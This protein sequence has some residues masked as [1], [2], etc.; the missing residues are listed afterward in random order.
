MIAAQELRIGNLIFIDN[1]FQTITGIYNQLGDNDKVNYY[2][3]NKEFLD[4]NIEDIEPIP[5]TPEILEKCGFENFGD[6]FRLNDFVIDYIG[7]QY[8]IMGNGRTIV[9]TSLHH[10]Q[11]CY[12]FNT[13]QELDIKL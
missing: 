1:E 10:L 5:L 8:R 6:N 7:F 12:Y 13:G 9:L 11:N 2:V 4:V 3:Q